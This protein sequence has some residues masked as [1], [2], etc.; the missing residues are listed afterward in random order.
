[1]PDPQHVHPSEL[2]TLLRAR[3]EELEGANEVLAA[4]LAARDADLEAALAR[5]AVL[6]DQVEEM[7]RRLGKDSSTSSKAPVVGQPVREEAQ[8]PVAARPVRAASGQAARSAV[9]DA[10]AV[11]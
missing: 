5:L 9:L 8:G 11:R 2:V 10:E 6:A 4:Q 7:R 1:M 3:I